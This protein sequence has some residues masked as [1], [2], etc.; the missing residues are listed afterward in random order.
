[1][2]PQSDWLGFPPCGRQT[3]GAAAS[4]AGAPGSRWTSSWS[5]G[6]EI[7]TGPNASVVSSL[8]GPPWIRSDPQFHVGPIDPPPPGPSWPLALQSASECPCIP[9]ASV[10][11]VSP[12]RPPPSGTVSPLPLC[13]GPSTLLPGPPSRRGIEI[14]SGPLLVPG[15]FDQDSSI[16]EPVQSSPESASEDCT[17]GTIPGAYI[18]FATDLIDSTRATVGAHRKMIYN[19]T[20]ESSASVEGIPDLPL[21]ALGLPPGSSWTSSTA[22]GTPPQSPSPARTLPWAGAR[23]W[24]GPPPDSSQATARMREEATPNHRYLDPPTRATGTEGPSPGGQRIKWH[25]PPCTISQGRHGTSTWLA[26]VFGTLHHPSRPSP[27]TQ[28][29][30]S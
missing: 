22:V 24:L 15:R 7:G 27:T 16:Q 9:P 30:S 19:L 21:A 26:G 18:D 17:N 25:H 6:T 1:M 2:T 20:V 8:G 14:K 4:P 29:P 10:F 12:H 5:Q 3:A 28:P 11:P 23:A 13:P